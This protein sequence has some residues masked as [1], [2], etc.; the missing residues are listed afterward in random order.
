M[1]H[2]LHTLLE[3]A[4]L[5]RG[6]NIHLLLLGDGANKQTLQ[7]RADQM[8]LDNVTFLDSVPKEQ[9]VRY[10]SLL[11]ASIIHLR[12]TPLFKTVIPSKLFEALAMGIPVLHGVEGESADIVAREEAGLVFEPENAEELANALRRLKNDHDL[13]A[14]LRENALKAAGKYDRSVLAMRMLGLLEKLVKSR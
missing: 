6:E 7:A 10:W 9:V 3:A 13:H 8:K 11:D 2:A 14:R 1:A 5:V 12:K 4:R